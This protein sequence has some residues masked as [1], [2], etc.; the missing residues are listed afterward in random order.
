M[1]NDLLEITMNDFF[2]DYKIEILNLTG[3]DSTKEQIEAGV[4]DAYDIP[5]LREC[6]YIDVDVLLDMEKDYL[7]QKAYQIF[8]VFIAPW[9]AENTKRFLEK[10]SAEYPLSAQ[11]FRNDDAIQIR[12]RMLN[13]HIMIGGEPNLMDVLKESYS[14]HGI[15][16]HTAL[17]R[18]L[19]VSTTRDD[20]SSAVETA[21]KHIGFYPP[22][23]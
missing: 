13:V 23:F 6:L 8:T 10:W 18:K 14:N 22:V 21:Y 4:V 16:W 15:I 9:I 5:R 3:F 2:K 12:R 11:V 17:M 20:K 19:L 1:S 7:E